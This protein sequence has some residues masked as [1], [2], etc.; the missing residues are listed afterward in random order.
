VSEFDR[1]VQHSGVAIVTAG[2][3]RTYVL[4]G[5]RWRLHW[6]RAGASGLPAA[7]PRDTILSERSLTDVERAELRRR[8]CYWLDLAGRTRSTSGS[9]LTEELALFLGRYGIRLPR[10]RA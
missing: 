10:T 2:T 8:G 4:S 6:L 5:R 7:V 1:F 3:A 9:P